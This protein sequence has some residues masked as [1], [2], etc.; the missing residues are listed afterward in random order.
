MHFNNGKSGWQWCWC[1]TLCP[2]GK[3]THSLRLSCVNWRWN[4][5]PRHF[6]N[7]NWFVRGVFPLERNRRGTNCRITNLQ[8]CGYPGSTFANHTSKQGLRNH[9]YTVLLAQGSLKEHLPAWWNLCIPVSGWVLFYGGESIP[10]EIAGGSLYSNFRRYDAELTTS[11]AT[12]R[13]AQPQIHAYKKESQPRFG[14]Y[15][16][17]S[18]CNPLGHFSWWVGFKNLIFFYW[19]ETTWNHHHLN[20]IS[21]L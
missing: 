7:L 3:Q 8:N 17:G 4:L 12:K 10:V 14:L 11:T 16:K 1:R 13:G 6:I 19:T 5:S 20:G 15:K 9:L 2:T 18:L 21:F